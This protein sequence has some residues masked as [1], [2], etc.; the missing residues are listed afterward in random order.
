MSLYNE[1]N[2][3][4]K[5]EKYAE[6]YDILIEEIN[7]KQDF[8]IYV[9]ALYGRICRKLSKQ[10]EFLQSIKPLLLSE[11]MVDFTVEFFA[12]IIGC[13]FFLVNCV[14][15]F[16]NFDV[17]FFLGVKGFFVILFRKCFFDEISASSG[18]F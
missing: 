14:L 5:E 4:Y 8:N 9:Y 6:A 12:D 13:V 17:G 18:Y 16:L 7:I 15:F 3:L 11:E 2:K 1:A 10:K